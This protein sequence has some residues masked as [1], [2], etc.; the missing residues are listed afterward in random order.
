MRK[1][2]LI[3]GLVFWGQQ[4]G[5]SQT[6][7]C[8]NQIKSWYTI[9]ENKVNNVDKKNLFEM[10]FTMNVVYTNRKQLDSI[11]YDAHVISD[12]SKRYFFSDDSKVYQNEKTTASVSLKNKE[13]HLFNTPADEYKNQLTERY[14]LF[15]D[16]LFSSVDNA[17]LV[18]KNQIK[19]FFER[20][21]KIANG[22]KEI[23]FD[24]SGNQ[25][26]KSIQTV[27]YPNQKFSH[28]KVDYHKIDF[29]SETDVLNKKL[30]ANIMRGK[31]LIPAYKNYTLYDHR[32]NK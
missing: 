9:L 3:I 2:G 15:E 27:Y 7:E 26:V 22:L 24:F 23:S 19:L 17:R 5:W 8:V 14:Q 11:S 16:T 20:D 31:K 10:K 29:N 13:I 12:Q 28:I 30:L 4:I 18:N 6:Q 25:L 21:N 32:K 1:L